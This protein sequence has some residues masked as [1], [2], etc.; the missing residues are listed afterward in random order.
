M[1]YQLWHQA[2]TEDC[3]KQVIPTFASL[4]SLFP[5][6]KNGSDNIQGLEL[7][8]KLNRGKKNQGKRTRRLVP[9]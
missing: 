7:V 6:W 2:Y 4:V 9:S 1:W 5:H 3:T 8:G